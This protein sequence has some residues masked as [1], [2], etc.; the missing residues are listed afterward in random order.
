MST[1]PKKKPAKS[2]RKAWVDTL[3]FDALCSNVARAYDSATADERVS[4]S[5]WYTNA[6]DWICRLSDD[7]FNWETGEITT[8]EQ[9]AGMVAALSPGVRWSTN[10]T[11]AERAMQRDRGHRYSTYG[12][13]VAKAFEIVDGADPRVVLRGPKE[14]AFFECLL[15]PA[16]REWVVLDR[17]ALR[18]AIDWRATIDDVNRWTSRARV[19]ETISRVYTYVARQLQI[20][21][22]ELQAITWLWFRNNHVETR[23]RDQ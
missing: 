12:K 10:Q 4:G 20:S 9:V 16:N 8:A 1:T 15:N 14:R 6:H 19:V 2:R 13:Q 23:Y 22:C 5:F 7:S 21:P 11:D 3:C 17:H 18:V